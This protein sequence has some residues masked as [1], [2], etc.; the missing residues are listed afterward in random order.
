M[1]QADRA[2]L[3]QTLKSAGYKFEK[4][5]RKY[6]LEE[7]EQIR[8]TMA[9]D[10]ER[11]T[12]IP[13]KPQDPRELPSQRRGQED[14][15][16]RVDLD[17]TIWYQEEIIKSSTAKPRGKRVYREIGTR[18]KEVTIDTEDGFTETFEVAGEEKIPL[19]ITVGIPTWQPGISKPPHSPF[20]I[21][22][23]RDARGYDRI[24]VERYFGGADVLPENVES[25]YV[26]NLI[27]Y[28][29]HSVN[30]AI[31]REYNQLVQTKRGF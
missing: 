4:H 22:T 14:E 26:G 28:D 9:A 12:G 30:T 8:D 18:T 17:G 1:A 20:K 23:Y 3:Y 10:V 25:I 11:R 5:Y 19:E 29:I 7:L 21:V 15:P 13:A 24:E 27:C 31:R 2:H 16:I 6:S